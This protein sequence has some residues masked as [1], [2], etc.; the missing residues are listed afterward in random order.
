LLLLHLGDLLFQLLHPILQPLILQPQEIESIQ[1]L[2]ALN[3]RP[4]E[5]AF[6]P[7]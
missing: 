4:F 1:K 7:G 3:L 2:L 6:E 5:G